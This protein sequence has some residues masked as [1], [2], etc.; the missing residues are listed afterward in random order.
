MSKRVLILVEGQTEERFVKDVLGPH[1]YD[2]Q[3]FFYPTIL[4]T[5]RVKDGS[6]FKGGVTNFAKFENDAQRLLNS[7][8]DALVTTLLDYYRLP[9]DFPGM[10]S[11]PVHGTA[12]QRVSHIET[13]ITQHFDSLPNFLPFLALHEFEAWLFS[14]STELPRAMIEPLKQPEFE[15]IRNSVA[16]PEEI[17]ERP[18][19]APSKRIVALFPAYK[20]TL[21]GPTTAARIGLDTIRAECPH[22][23]DWMNKLETFAK[24]D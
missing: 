14:S 7:A 11:R 17:N 3:L 2:L 4:V 21:H 8:G 5:K 13:A 22:F 18:E 12:L 24:L 16:T 1:F 10:D 23:D 9:L 6:N 20:K 15:A 19:Y